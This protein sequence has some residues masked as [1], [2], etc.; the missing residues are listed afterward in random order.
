[1]RFKAD[2]KI[3]IGTT[4]PKSQLQV[5]GGDIYIENVNS[6]VI[7]KSPDGNCWRMTVD[8]SGNPVF[9]SIACP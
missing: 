8:N 1:M 3:G 5:T 6:G 9:T 7:M 4:D 2:G